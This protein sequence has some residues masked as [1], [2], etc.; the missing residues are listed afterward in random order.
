VRK[1]EIALGD[2]LGLQPLQ[3]GVFLGAAGVDAVAEVRVGEAVACA[4][5]D[6]LPRRQA[7][8]FERR[9]LETGLGE[10]FLGIA[11]GLALH[12]GA[13]AEGEQCE[14]GDAVFHNDCSFRRG[15]LRATT[16]RSAAGR[17]SSSRMRS[18][19]LRMS[20]AWLGR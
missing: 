18:N 1:G 3:L 2:A 15:C 4:V 14:S 10:D 12:E 11:G 6:Q 7:G 20:V 17:L 19:V 8:T 9:A 16:R 13:G 5:G